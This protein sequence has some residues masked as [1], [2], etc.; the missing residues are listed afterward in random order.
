MKLTT[1]GRY[2]V[3][4]MLD[5]A[6]HGTEGPVA[7]AEISERQE[8]S[9]SCLEQLFAKLRKNNL[10]KSTRG[11]GGGYRVARPLSQVAVAQIIFA[12]DESVDATSCAGRQDCLTHGRCLTHD[13][14]ESLSEQIEEF[15][16]NVSLQ[17]LI[18]QHVERTGAS[19][20][21]AAGLNTEQKVVLRRHLVAPENSISL[22]GIGSH[23]IA[24]GS[25]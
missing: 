9:L 12:V 6:L 20:G 18:D 24:S 4:A 7:L 1:K 16:R 10:V 14:W 21:Q 3:T 2:A 22:G 19:L 5:L 13:L 15:L 23:G 8:L 25:R 17:D 11:P